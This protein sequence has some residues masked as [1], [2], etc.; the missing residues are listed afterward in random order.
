M[1]DLHKANRKSGRE[2]LFYL[3]P[4]TC[5][6]GL[7]FTGDSDPCVTCS[8]SPR[9]GSIHSRHSPFNSNTEAA[10]SVLRFK[11]DRAEGEGVGNVRVYVCVCVVGGQ[12]KVPKACICCI[13]VC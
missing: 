10:L 8:L 9:R 11:G 1:S 7:V 13:Y 6:H 4:L 5:T 3:V 2:L 12:E